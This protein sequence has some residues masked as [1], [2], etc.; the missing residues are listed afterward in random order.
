MAVALERERT[1]FAVKLML[2]KTLVIQR[3]LNVNTLEASVQNASDHSDEAEEVYSYPEASANHDCLH[4]ETAT[5]RG[6]R[7]EPN[8]ANSALRR[9]GDRRLGRQACGRSVL[10]TRWAHLAAMT[11][12][13]R[14]ECA[15]DCSGRSCPHGQCDSWVPLVGRLLYPSA[16]PCRHKRWA[17][18]PHAY[19]RRRS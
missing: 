11:V 14:C 6:E 3:R 10:A 17:G 18:Q 13:S 12:Q 2:T 5:A 8:A 4:G 16:V 7:V 15:H 9:P 1:Y 19:E